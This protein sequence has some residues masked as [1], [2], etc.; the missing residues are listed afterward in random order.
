[1]TSVIK[2]KKVSKILCDL[3]VTQQTH[4]KAG[5]QFFTPC[6]PAQPR[7]SEIKLPASARV[8]NG[9]FYN[10]NHRASQIRRLKN[11]YH[12]LPWKIEIDN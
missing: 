3:R 6:L 11:H 2:K 8:Q 12:R 10:R 1:M 7:S 5:D 4:D 9:S